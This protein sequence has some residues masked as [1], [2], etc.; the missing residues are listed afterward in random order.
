MLTGSRTR[1]LTHPDARQWR[2]PELHSRH[3]INIKKQNS[4]S[5]FRSWW[6]NINNKQ[7]AAFHHLEVGGIT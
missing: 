4:I 5:S 6:H 2:E 3:K 1:G 7:K